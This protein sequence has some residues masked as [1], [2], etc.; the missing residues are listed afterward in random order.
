MGAF[1]TLVGVCSRAP[2][3][4]EAGGG[5]AGCQFAVEVVDGA[6]RRD[7]SRRDPSKTTYRITCSGAVAR[8]AAERVRVGA[9]VVVVGR[10]VPLEWRG[11]DGQ[12]HVALETTAT[13]VEC[14]GSDLDGD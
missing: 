8:S 9:R 5:R 12:R 11:R 7:G 13:E 14:E 2:D 1:I 6:E 3:T 4:F 10:L